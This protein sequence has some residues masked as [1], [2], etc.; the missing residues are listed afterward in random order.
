MLNVSIELLLTQ[1]SLGLVNGAYYALLSLGLCIIFGILDVVNFAH[2][3]LYMMGAFFAWVLN[4]YFGLGYW[5]SLLLVPLLVAV[6]GI[7]IEQLAFRH[8]YAIHHV[9]GFLLTFGLVLML[10]SFFRIA[11][12]GLSTSYAVPTQLTGVLDFGFMLMP[13]YRAWVVVASAVLC[14]GTWWVIEKTFLGSYLRA[15]IERRELVGAFG[16]NVPRLVTLTFAFGC[17]LAGLGGVFAAP[18]FPI[19]PYMGQSITTVV[20][21]VVVIG[22]LGSIP[23]AI[24]GGYVLGMVE[25]LSQAFYPEASSVSIFLIMML[26]LL[27]KKSGFAGKAVG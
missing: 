5:W 13:I 26:V 10:E 16:I 17:A 7:V 19:T 25:G 27:L 15:A 22:G 14:F 18:I 6:F 11:F 12:A 8:L 4:Y 3:A 21:A 1:M 2:G 20:F 9:Y 23:G 24:L